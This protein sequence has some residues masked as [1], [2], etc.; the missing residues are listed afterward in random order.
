MIRGMSEAVQ[1]HFGSVTHSS[2]DHTEMGRRPGDAAGTAAAGGGGGEERFGNANSPAAVGSIETDRRRRE[3]R[4]EGAGGEGGGDNL[5]DGGA[6]LLVLK[7]AGGKAFCA[8]GDV[9][10]IAEE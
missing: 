2:G 9:K 10:A 8:G 5:V 1:E 3:A 4:G 6:R 7:G